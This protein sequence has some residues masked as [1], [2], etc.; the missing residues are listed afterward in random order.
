M[1]FRTPPKKK[2]GFTIESIEVQTF[3]TRYSAIEAKGLVGLIV[4]E[5]TVRTCR[6]YLLGFL[7]G[8]NQIAVSAGIRVTLVNMLLSN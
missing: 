2:G 7:S 4:V 3:P 8:S 1:I 5:N 6:G